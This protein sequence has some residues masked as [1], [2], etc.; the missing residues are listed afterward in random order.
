MELTGKRWSHM[1][2]SLYTTQ[3]NW[4][5]SWRLEVF[6]CILLSANVIIKYII[7]FYRVHARRTRRSGDHRR[8]Y[9]FQSITSDSSSHSRSLFSVL[10]GD[11]GVRKIDSEIFTQIDR[12]S[13]VT[14]ARKICGYVRETYDHSD[15]TIGRKK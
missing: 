13:V 2:L 12:W 7:L 14:N 5:A 10:S 9:L 6:F 3:Y 1:N 11:S 15:C 4:T 8:R